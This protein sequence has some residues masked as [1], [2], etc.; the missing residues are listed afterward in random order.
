MTDARERKGPSDE[1]LRAAVPRDGSGREFLIG[2][3]VLLGLMSFITVLFLLTDPATL[4]GRYMLV[5]EM[6]N[7]GGIRR[8]DPVQLRGVNIGRIHSFEMTPAGRVAITMEIEGQWSVAEGSVA[9]LTS[10]GIFGGRTMEIDPGSGQQLLTE[11]DTIPGLDEGGGLMETAARLGTD[12]E[13]VLQRLETLLDTP[14]VRSV[15]ASAQDV[16][17][18]VRE[19]RGLLSEQ[20]D[21]LAELTATMTRAARGLETTANEAGPDVAS[22]AARADSLLARMGETRERLDR[23]LG[24]LDSVLGRMERGEGTLGRL[25][26]D[27]ALYSNMAAAASSLDSLLV[28]IRLNPKRYVTIEIF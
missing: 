18:L 23:V 25:S 5:T 24:S 21:E 26:R 6:A 7:A 9:T 27:E 20:R 22:A 1:E 16:E 28:D 17:G 8:G 4:R 15:Q 12:A 11:W 10:S 14:T 13:A 2:A 19:F 3:F